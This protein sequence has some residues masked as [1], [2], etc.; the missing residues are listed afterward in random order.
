MKFFGLDKFF[1]IIFLLLGVST[2]AQAACWDKKEYR[3][4]ENFSELDDKL[5]LSYKDAVSCK[6]LDDVKVQLGKLTYKTDLNGYV[7]LPMAPFIEAG[8][9]DMPM[10]I[11]KAGYTSVKTE[12]K[13]VA[14]TVLNKRMLLSPSL[15]GN[16]MRFILQWNDEPKDLDLHLQGSDFHVSYRHMRAAGEA[17]LD[18]DEQ[19]GYGPETITLKNVKNNQHYK[20]SVVNYS[21]EV[22]FD[23][24]AKVLVYVGDHLDSI[25]PLYGSSQRKVDV[26]EISN[27]EIN[28]LIKAPTAASANVI[29]GW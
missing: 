4:I 2:L 5:I 17:K 24:N 29:P 26:L 19:D 9:L 8:N 28:K 3:D 21:G 13:V 20:V 27:A 10:M 7:S 16:S 15:S 1:S 11:S 6:A 23:E 12:L 22:A 18:Q 14:G 25:I